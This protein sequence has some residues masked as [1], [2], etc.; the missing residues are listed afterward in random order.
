MYGKITMEFFDNDNGGYSQL[1]YVNLAWNENLNV[2]I[3]FINL[4]G[5]S[6][7]YYLNLLGID[8]FGRADFE[9]LSDSTDIT[10]KM[11]KNVY[12]VDSY[13]NGE[14]NDKN[15]GYIR[16]SDVCYGRDGCLET[17]NCATAYTIV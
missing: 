1:K 2:S 3:D 8:T 11:S 15:Y 4:D 9:F 7:L 12:C 6:N 5:Q 10:I 16:D 13:C 17:C 14:S